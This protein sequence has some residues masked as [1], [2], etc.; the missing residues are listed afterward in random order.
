MDSVVSSAWSKATFSKPRPCAARSAA[1]SAG[2]NAKAFGT[3]EGASVGDGE[4]TSGHIAVAS[5]AG[6][7]CRS[8]WLRRVHCWR[9]FFLP[10][11][12]RTPFFIVSIHAKLIVG[13]HAWRF[14][15]ICWCHLAGYCGERCF[16][17]FG[18]AYQSQEPGGEISHA[19]CKA[20]RFTCRTAVLLSLLLVRA[21]VRLHTFCR[22][23]ATFVEL[24]R[25]SRCWL[26]QSHV[27]GCVPGGICGC[28]AGGALLRARLR[29][30]RATQRVAED[31]SCVQAV[32]GRV[33]KFSAAV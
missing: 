13:V 8:R 17:V 31:V 6:V 1:V 33:H 20:A 21:G 4:A 24:L 29:W 7:Y 2:A 28:F 12:S 16:Q 25:M 5:V 18:A 15:G 3:L 26:P 9:V 32:M 27:I 14:A 19:V 22:R 11:A 30:P 23:H 10:M